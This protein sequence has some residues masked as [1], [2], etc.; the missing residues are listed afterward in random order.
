MDV[1]QYRIQID[2]QNDGAFDSDADDVTASVMSCVFSSGSTSGRP[3][4]DP[5]GS[6]TLRLDNSDGRYTRQNPDSPL[7]GLL[8]PGVRL[9]VSMLDPDGE[10]W[11]VRWTGRVQSIGTD[12]GNVRGF[13]IAEVTATGALSRLAAMQAEMPMQT[14]I[15]TGDAAAA[16]LAASGV[17]AS[18]FQ[19]DDGLTTMSL[20]YATAGTGLLSALRQLEA[21]ELG[22]VMES[23]DGRVLFRERGWMDTQEVKVTFGAGGLNLWDAR[24]TEPADSV[25]NRVT[26]PVRVYGK[27]D[28][29]AILALVTDIQNQQGGPAI[30]LP[31]GGLVEVRIN[32]PGEHAAGIYAGVVAWGM[33]EYEANT[34]SDRSGADV[35][36]QISATYA[37]AA[38]SRTV[39]FLNTSSTATAYIV[40]LRQRGQA[41]KPEDYVDVSSEDANASD[42]V[43]RYG[44]RE[45]PYAPQWES[46]SAAAKQLADY[47]LAEHREPL[48]RVQITIRANYDTAHMQAAANLNVG[49]RVAVSDADGGCG[50]YVDSEFVID[51]TRHSI[52]PGGMHTMTI[53]ATAPPASDLA[54]YESSYAP[55]VQ[56]PDDSL[57]T[58]PEKQTVRR[59][60]ETWLAEKPVLTERAETDTS[61]LVLYAYDSYVV[62]FQ[63]LF[64]Y[65][66]GQEVD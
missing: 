23:P 18:D 56:P 2:W 45:Y 36:S 25:S 8:N 33:T 37:D 1:A 11:R 40:F 51:A 59:A 31:P 55:P 24:L 57:F 49:D 42:S 16:L 63:A 53:W 58:P 48:T 10:T 22:R 34:H 35:T 32:V 66:D 15:T 54:A 6:C 28:V 50:L 47:L 38:G 44:R 27:T 20:Y 65:L 14:A 64:T 61:E 19:C 21:Q 52:D 30:E 3:T 43:Q 29:D 9:R 7:A 60:W 17:A 39:T 12:P 4:P 41:L 26:V 46:D 13:Q 62:A 5:A